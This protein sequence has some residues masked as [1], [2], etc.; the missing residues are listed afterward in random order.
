MPDSCW[1]R[2]TLETRISDARTRKRHPGGS[3]DSDEIAAYAAGLSTAGDRSGT[4]VVLGM[5]PELRVLALSRFNR[6]FAVDSNPHSISLYRDWIATA[7]RDRET[8]IEA[9]WLDLARGITQPVEAVLGDGVFANLPDA[10]TQSKL[11]D[12]VSKILAPGG[13]LVTRKAVI[14]DGFAASQHRAEVL[15]ARFRAGELDE[16]EFGFDTRL[17]GYHEPCYDS[18]T[19]LL[20]NARLFEICASRH[21]AGELTDREHAAI[22]RYYFGGLNCILPQRDWEGL[23][24]ESGF[25]YRIYRCRGKTW[26]DYCPVYACWQRQA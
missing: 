19:C 7:D 23:L 24:H 3:P 10:A 25:D 15:L 16:A 26:Y 22:R 1:D 8:F 21:K 20:D 5:T 2:Q 4:A 9:D 13:R 11:L 14:P 12:F 18:Q 17:R 6:V